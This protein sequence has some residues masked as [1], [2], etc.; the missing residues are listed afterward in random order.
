MSDELWKRIA[1]RRG[2]N[3]P[4]YS[5]IGVLLVIACGGVVVGVW[6]YLFIN[7]LS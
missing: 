4:D 2:A 6:V 1:N 3:N 7:I 5:G